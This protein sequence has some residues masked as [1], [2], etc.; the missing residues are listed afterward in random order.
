MTTAINTSI[1]GDLLIACAARTGRGDAIEAVDPSTGRTIGP[2][3]HYATS[4]DVRAATQLAD[5][6]FD[7]YRRTTSEARAR[8]LESVADN[9]DNL[10]DELIDRASAE[11]GLPRARL[12]G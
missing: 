1:T 10:G 3:F 4:D 12:Q 7:I 2:T 5:D 11:S 8:F 6:A 9:I